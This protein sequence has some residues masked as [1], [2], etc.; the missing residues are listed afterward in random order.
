MPRLKLDRMSPP[1]QV[2]A[3]S[4]RDLDT[5][6]SRRDVVVPVPSSNISEAPVP[7]GLDRIATY[8]HPTR[9]VSTRLHQAIST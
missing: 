7:Y 4:Y 3:L 6:S 5:A 2:S 1:W 9:R 8:F